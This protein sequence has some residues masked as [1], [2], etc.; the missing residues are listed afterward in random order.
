[1]LTSTLACLYNREEEKKV[2]G[3]REEKE[4]QYFL[5][6]TYACIVEIGINNTVL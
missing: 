5:A 4:K 1:M 2:E 3:K 6:V